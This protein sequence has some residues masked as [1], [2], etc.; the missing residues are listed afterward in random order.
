MKTL[1][2]RRNSGTY[3]KPVSAE[4][5]R[6]RPGSLEADLAG[7]ASKIPK[8][9]LERLPP[10]LASKIDYYVYGVQKR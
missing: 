6:F 1:V 8:S 2:K 3:R 5:T 9:E 10:D 7:I 4:P